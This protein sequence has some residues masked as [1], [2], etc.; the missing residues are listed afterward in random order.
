MIQ[1]VNEWTKDMGNA[2]HKQRA[3]CPEDPLAS[4]SAIWIF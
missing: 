4:G 2:L 1:P 3:V